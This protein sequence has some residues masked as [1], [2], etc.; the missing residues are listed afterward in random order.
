VG[1]GGIEAEQDREGLRPAVGPGN[2]ST[3][4]RRLLD[5]GC[6]GR[7]VRIRHPRLAPGVELSEVEPVEQLAEEI[8]MVS[9][10]T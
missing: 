4:E 10:H 1:E 5:L 9:A 3:V 6:G 7:D 2:G 8:G